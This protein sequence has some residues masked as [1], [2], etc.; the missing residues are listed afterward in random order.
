MPDIKNKLYLYEA[1]ELRR[2][3]ELR[4]K[5]LNDLLSKQFGNIKEYR[6]HYDVQ[7]FVKIPE[8]DI[9]EIR[10]KI[11][12]IEFKK[13]KLHVAI[14]KI[15]NTSKL[16]INKETMTLNEAVHLRKAT[17]DRIKILRNLLNDAAYKKIIY[18]EGRNIEKIPYES[19]K[20][21]EEQLES[22]LLLFRELNRRIR[23][24]SFEKTVD[25][26]DEH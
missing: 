3:Y 10:K 15:N 20:E 11:R 2:E 9:S 8:L 21:T 12:K 22:N 23:K 24:I 19:F 14:Q 17:H 25:F 18:K 6:R 16:T 26:K 7:K 5:I 4:N 13:R 1:I